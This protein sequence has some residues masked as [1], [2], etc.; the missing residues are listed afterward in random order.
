LTNIPLL[1]E[2]Y[3]PPFLE[4]PGSSEY[5][6]AKVPK[7]SPFAILDFNFSS[8]FF[9]SETADELAGGSLRI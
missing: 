8:Y 4:D 9:V 5:K 1:I 6:I 7:L 2:V 3:K